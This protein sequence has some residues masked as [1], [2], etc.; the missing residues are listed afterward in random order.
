LSSPSPVP[1]LSELLTENTILVNASASDWKDAVRK[2]GELLVNIDAAEPRYINAM[3]KFC[4]EHHAY[5][6]IAPGI[7]ILHAR[8][9]D[10]MK[11]VGFSLVTLK[12]PVYF[13]HAKND[14]VD[15]VVA[16]GG[17][18][19]SSHI[20]AL[21]Q[22]AKLLSNNEVGEKVRKARQKEEILELLPKGEEASEA[23]S[24]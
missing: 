22:L 9:E 13:G 6:V 8:P 19:D 15:L 21:A 12:K 7:A 16:L 23:T 20:K 5:I 17:P 24:T 11:R 2:A 14:P 3:I 10:G 1:K 18:D 4:E